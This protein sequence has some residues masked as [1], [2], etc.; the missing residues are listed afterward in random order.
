[1]RRKTARVARSRWR[2]RGRRFPLTI[3][4]SSVPLRPTNAEALPSP[5]AGAEFLRASSEFGF[6]GYSLITKTRSYELLVEA[7]F[8]MDEAEVARTLASMVK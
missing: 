5:V 8:A 7:K 6:T 4:Q 2:S 1:M 3:T